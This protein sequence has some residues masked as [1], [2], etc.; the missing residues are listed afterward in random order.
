MNLTAKAQPAGSVSFPAYGGEMGALIRAHD[1]S[2]SPLGPIDGWSDIL[3][4]A[5]SV[6]LPAQ[7]QIVMFWGPEF[8]ALYNDAYSATIGHKHPRALGRPARESWTELWDDLE[9]L[10]LRAQAGET[11]VARDRP[12]QIDRK[13]YLETVYFDIS[14]SPACNERGDVEG[15]VC[16]VDETTEQVATEQRLREANERMQLALNSGAV[17]GTWVWD[18]RSNTL[19]ADAL[20]A[21]SFGLDEGVVNE[22]V[23][24]DSAFASIHPDDRDKVRSLKSAAIASRE[25]YRAEYRVQQPDGAWRWVEANGRCEFDGEGRPTRF[26]GVLLDIHERKLTEQ[27]LRASEARF[28]TMSDAMPGFAWTAD[29]NGM[30]DHTSQQWLDYSGSTPEQSLGA[31]WASFVHPDDVE[32]AAASWMHSVQTGQAYDI[33]FRLRRRDG[34][35][36]WF[37]ARALP[38]RDET[39]TIVRWVGTCNDIEDTVAAREVLTRSRAELERRV[40]EAV[41]ERNTIWNTT[42]NLICV[43]D[44]AGRIRSC[45]PA[46]RAVLGWS[47]AELRAMS[48]VDLEHP[49]DRARARETRSRIFDRTG[50]VTAE[51]RF[52]HKDGGHRWIA[53]TATHDGDAIYAIGRDIT[54][55]REQA[56]ALRNAEEQLRQAQKMEA[57]GQL[58]GGIAHDFNNLLTGIIGSLDLL[59]R[60]IAEGRTGDI[61]RFIEAAVG[62][63]EPRRLA[64]AAAAG[65]LAAPVA[66]HQA[67][68]LNA[69]VVVDPGSAAAARWANR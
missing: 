41:R 58:T 29:P 57:V 39:A 17:I 53:W 45:N 30:L 66:R 36:R 21:R 59:K 38:V 22:G 32:R 51:L 31:G 67:G 15:V 33:E 60:R 8:A 23:P 50:T 44:R 3:R 4:G 6:M 7:A 28:R 20:F 42:P 18:V 68:R 43:V 27:A 14:Y 37:L 49:D 47:E 63:R 48:I 16:I 34:I 9:P 64:D 19:N 1:W 46:W 35:Y 69:L 65:V 52:C 25:L 61:D 62:L 12:F 40:D 55:E 2:Q 26:P 11:V 56:Q 5:V 54:A 13:G 24:F 10:L